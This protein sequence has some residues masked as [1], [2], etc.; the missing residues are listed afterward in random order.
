MIRW[1]VVA[2]LILAAALVLES[3]LLAYS[4]YAYME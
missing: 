1:L 3:G 2:G 4:M